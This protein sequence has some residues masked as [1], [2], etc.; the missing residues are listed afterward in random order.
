MGAA[1]PHDLDLD[2]WEQVLT[3]RRR[4]RMDGQAE[5][6][7]SDSAGE[8]TVG[9]EIHTAM[10]AEIEQRAAPAIAALG[11]AR[12]TLAKRAQRETEHHGQ[13]SVALLR[14]DRP[15]ERQ[16]L[17]S[18]SSPGDGRDANPLFANAAHE[19]ARWTTALAT[20]LTEAAETAGA[21]HV[22]RASPTSA[23]RPAVATDACFIDSLDQQRIILIGDMIKGEPGRASL[24]ERNR[25]FDPARYRPAPPND[26]H[27]RI[28]WFNH[29]DAYGLQSGVWD[30]FWAPWFV[31]G[32]ALVDT[33]A[34]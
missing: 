30:R 2:Q 12:Q 15:Q 14:A 5:R 29:P 25:Q 23:G 11:A 6:P 17:L 34:P 9:R 8:N 33:A 20:P 3:V 4:A 13:V 1:G 28:V 31:A 32:G 21:R 18:L 7:A 16:W 26:L 22:D 19:R 24:D 27:V 10:D